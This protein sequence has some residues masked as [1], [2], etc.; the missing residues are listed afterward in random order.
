[1]QVLSPVQIAVL[2]VESWPVLPDL[3]S[4]GCIAESQLQG[5]GLEDVGGAAS[6]QPGQ[7][8]QSSDELNVLADALAQPG[9]RLHPTM[10]AWGQSTHSP[11]ASG[12]PSPRPSSAWPNSFY[13]AAHLESPACKSGRPG[14]GQQ[15]LRAN[16]PASMS[17]FSQAIL[18][19][20]RR[21]ATGRACRPQYPS[22]D[23]LCSRILGHQ[24]Q[25]AAGELEQAWDLQGAAGTLTRHL[26]EHG[27]PVGE[28][29][30]PAENPPLSLCQ[31]SQNDLGITRTQPAH[32]GLQHD[33]AHYT[34]VSAGQSSRDCS[35][36]SITDPNLERPLSRGFM[37]LL[38]TLVSQHPSVAF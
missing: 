5:S 28:L 18:P 12:S 10:D 22:T 20:S 32:A 33:A 7:P 38:E 6:Q 8:P 27:S 21:S 16:P 25:S 35:C 19:T 14:L 4:L 30:L 3:I 17:I 2:S 37:D 34:P 23:P 9:G 15:Q 1:M 36:A 31:A 13:E 11:H 24:V 26:G 29:T